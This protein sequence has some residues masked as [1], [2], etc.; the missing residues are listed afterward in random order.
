MIVGR[1][2]VQLAAIL[3]VISHY[4]FVYIKKIFLLFLSIPFLFLF[5]S[6]TDESDKTIYDTSL[7]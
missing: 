1:Q 7:S 2:Y 5:E 6:G 3:Y 4:A